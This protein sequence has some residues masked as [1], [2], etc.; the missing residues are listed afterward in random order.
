VAR[1]TPGTI[2][3][4]RGRTGRPPAPAGLPSGPE[5]R[6]PIPQVRAAQDDAAAA[7]GEVRVAEAQLREVLDSTPRVSPRLAAAEHAVVAT[8]A[9]AQHGAQDV[10]THRRAVQDAEGA[11]EAAEAAH[12]D[13]LHSQ[14]QAS[15]GQLVAARVTAETTSRA[16]TAAR[17]RLVDAEEDRAAAEGELAAAEDHLAAVREQDPV[18]PAAVITARVALENAHRGLEAAHEDLAAAQRAAAGDRPPAAVAPEFASL[19]AFV[20][21]YVL[22][23]WRHRP[24][25]GRWCA[26]WWR[27]SE[28]V[29]RFEAVW[30]AFE[31]MRRES[32]PGLST[33]WRDHL[34]PHLRVLTAADGTFAG[35]VAT[36]HE[37]VHQQQPPWAATPAPDGQFHTDPQSPRQPRRV[38]APTAKEA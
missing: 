32:A 17:G 29:T 20:E 8:R 37:T 34:D 14:T 15:P 4:L 31:V 21:D 23:N 13:L 24:S 18:E 38:T 10:D 30:E 19:D 25:E 33:W 11:V 3:T 22:P 35:C 9:T 16:L 2:T 5:P 7:E 26:T 1:K 27:H 6:S 12:A 36:R 28:A